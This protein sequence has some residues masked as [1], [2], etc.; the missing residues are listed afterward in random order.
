MTGCRVAV[1]DLDAG[2]VVRSVVL[3]DSMKWQSGHVIAA[4]TDARQFYVALTAKHTD[5][6]ALISIRASDYAVTMLLVFAGPEQFPWVAA[7]PRTNQLYLA[8]DWGLRIKVFDPATRRITPTFIARRDTMTYG[9]ILWYAISPTEQRIYASYHGAAGRGGTGVDWID[10]GDPL[11]SCVDTSPSVAG[12]APGI[13]CTNAHGKVI[14]YERG[15]LA[16]TAA[17]LALFDSAG[18]RVRSYDVGLGRYTHFM[19]FA[20]D[21]ARAAVF[22]LSPCR[23]GRFAAEL[24]SPAGVSVVR[25]AADAPSVRILNPTVCGSQAELSRDGSIL[26]V[27]DGGVVT[28]VDSRTGNVLRRIVVT[29][30]DDAISLLAEISAVTIRPETGVSPA[31]F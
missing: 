12:T 25:I 18:N 16:A 2:R 3:A 10:L 21:T 5:S 15:F 17:E 1:L 6:T 11:R 30:S 7:G 27:L 22:A 23:R 4:S 31:S 24:P 20:V 29:S 28:T 14:P 19:E 13:G 8:T 26:V 9:P